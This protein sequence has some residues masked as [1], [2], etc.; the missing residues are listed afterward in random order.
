MPSFDFRFE[1][2]YVK[3]PEAPP[4][5]QDKLPPKLPR[6]EEARRIIER[7]AADLREIIKKLRRKLN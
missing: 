7:Y 1:Y 6:L 2:R 3:P 4:P 5:D